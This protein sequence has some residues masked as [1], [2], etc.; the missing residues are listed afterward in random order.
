MLTK[1]DG[2]DM[3]TRSRPHVATVAALLA[4]LLV[5]LG[6]PVAAQDG[7]AVWQALRQP[8]TAPA[9]GRSRMLTDVDAC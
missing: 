5:R 1:A 7:A 2:A 3:S 9:Y 4:G 6:G 8:G